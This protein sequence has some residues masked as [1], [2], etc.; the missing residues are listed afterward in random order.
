MSIEI[1][2]AL[3]AVFAALSSPAHAVDNRGHADSHRSAQYCVPQY[4]DLSDVT[5]VYC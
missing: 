1:I 2:M 3:I 5:K 4:E